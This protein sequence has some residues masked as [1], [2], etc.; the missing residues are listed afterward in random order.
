MVVAA[1]YYREIVVGWISVIGEILETRVS[2]THLIF[3]KTKE[4][5]IKV[6]SY[7]ICLQIV[8]EIYNMNKQLFFASFSVGADLLSVTLKCY[9]IAL[10]LFLL[11]LC[12]YPSSAVYFSVY[13]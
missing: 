3:Q 2:E 11:K 1:A 7:G 4:D 9:F 5:M 10:L 13:L 8:K 12:K 6:D